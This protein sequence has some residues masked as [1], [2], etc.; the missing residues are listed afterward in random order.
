MGRASV[1]ENKT[2][3]QQCREACGMTRAEA[4]EAMQ[5]VT[6]SRIEKIENEKTTAAPEEVMAMAQ[7]YARPELCN[8]YCT[9]ECAI[10]R[11]WVPEIREKPIE[12]I[13]LEMLD[14]LNNLEKD[15]NRLIEITSD[16]VIHDDQ[17]EDFVRIRA[18]LW[19]MRA[20][21]DSL[22]LWFDTAVAGGSVNE[23]ILR[24]AL[25]RVEGK[26]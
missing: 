6:D 15:R 1:K 12:A 8:H 19:R 14:T 9:H 17:I 13:V 4:S 7:A 2:V 5:F 20:V 22:R 26:A 11:V 16:G 10:G 23:E 21:V 18:Q 3:Y 25:R 24:D